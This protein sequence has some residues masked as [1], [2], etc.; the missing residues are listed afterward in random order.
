VI[1]DISALDAQAVEGDTGNTTALTFT[2]RL[3]AATN[4]DVSVDYSTSENTAAATFDYLDTSGTLTI[5][6]GNTA[7]TAQVEILPDNEIE[8]NES[9]TLTISNASYGNI[10]R[11]NATGTIIDDD[12]PAAELASGGGGGGG[13]GIVLI[14]LLPLLVIRH[15]KTR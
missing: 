11:A 7:A 10:I 15:L 6:S 2:V 3:S 9:L 12:L 8:T 4:Q 13:L 14:G 5:T 1:P